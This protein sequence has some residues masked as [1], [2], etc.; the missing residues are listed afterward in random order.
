MHGSWVQM[1]PFR[2]ME[3]QFGRKSKPWLSSEWH[4]MLLRASFPWPSEPM[5]TRNMLCDFLN[6]VR[7]GAQEVDFFCIVNAQNFEKECLPWMKKFN[8]GSASHVSGLFR[9]TPFP[10]P[11][12]Q[13]VAWH[14]LSDL[15]KGKLSVGEGF[16]FG[17]GQAQG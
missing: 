5:L 8:P 11:R 10:A 12:Y 3:K 7:Q 1:A 9:K 14:V 2:R 15:V 6:Q 4:A 13:A 17:A 16:R